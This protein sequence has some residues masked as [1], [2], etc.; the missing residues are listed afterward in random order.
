MYIFHKNTG[1]KISPGCFEL[2]SLVEDDGSPKKL[3]ANF[4][5][6]SSLLLYLLVVSDSLGGLD[7]P[8]LVI[9]VWELLS[10]AQLELLSLLS[11]TFMNLSTISDFVRGSSPCSGQGSLPFKIASSTSSK[12]DTPVSLLLLY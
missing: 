4:F 12:N 3:P 2:D 8:E 6:I 1:I 5:L 11:T 10:A 7:E 9:F